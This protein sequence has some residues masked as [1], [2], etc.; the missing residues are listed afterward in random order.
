TEAMTLA[1]NKGR[2]LDAD[3]VMATDPDADR[4]GVAV[5]DDEGEFLLL[6]GN[7]IFS[8]LA[9]YV[10]GSYKA[11]GNSFDD[12]YIVK[13]IVATNLIREIAARYEGRSEERRGG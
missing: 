11:A 12:S 2:E 8:L 3:L 10:L 7:Q 1:M 13:T 5:K 9:E 4:V 6:N